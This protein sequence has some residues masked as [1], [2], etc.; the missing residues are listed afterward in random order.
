MRKIKIRLVRP[1]TQKLMLVKLIKDCSG[2]GLRESKDL[3]DRLHDFKNIS[4]EMPIR[5]YESYDYNTGLTIPTNVDYRAKFI[6]GIKEIDGE[7]IVNG[8]I[9]WERNA[10]MLSLGIGDD[11]DYSDFIKEHIISNLDDSK[12]ILTFI[13]SKLSKEE[14]IEIFSKIEIE[15]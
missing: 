15:I 11:S 12:N 3:C 9:Q 5:D 6:S 14:L 2:L 8:G 13:L 10:K 7:F 4:V 1:T